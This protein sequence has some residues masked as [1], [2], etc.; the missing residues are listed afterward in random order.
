MCDELLA[1]QSRT[2]CDK[3][4]QCMTAINMWGYTPVPITGVLV[5]LFLW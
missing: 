4:G 5:L 2:T 3:S 1:G